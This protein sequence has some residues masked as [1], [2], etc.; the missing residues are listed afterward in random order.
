MG[1]LWLRFPSF[2]GTVQRSEIDGILLHDSH[3]ISNLPVNGRRWDNFVLLT[4]NVAPD[5]STGLIS[6]RG[7]SGIYNSNEVDGANNNQA[8]F[9]EAR[10]RS[11]GAPYVYSQ[12]SIQEFQSEAAAY[13]PERID[14]LLAAASTGATW[15][16][17]L[18]L[19]GQVLAYD[20][21]KGGQDPVSRGA[22]PP[23]ELP[24]RKYGLPSD[25]PAQA[26]HH[27]HRPNSSIRQPS[28]EPYRNLA[29]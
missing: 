27:Q 13:S 5:G 20:G 6:Y 7:V 28:T 14:V 3:I 18:G 23:C 1:L 15:R 10:G 29:A 24:H 19:R 2:G 11:I 9:S 21:R 22:A 25:P 16:A 17:E 26:E 4:P 8:F 12:D